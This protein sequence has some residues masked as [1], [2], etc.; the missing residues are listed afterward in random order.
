MANSPLLAIPLLSQSQAAKEQTINQMVS[1]LERATN[2]GQIL[3]FGGGNIV[4]PAVDLQRYFL[5]K[6]SGAASTSILT[7]TP[8]KRIF[9]IDNFSNGNDLTL[10]CTSDSIII[11]AGG[12]VMVYCDG[13]NLANICDSTVNGGSGGATTLLG[14]MDTPNSY[15]ASE[16]FVLRVKNDLTGIEFVDLSIGDLADV[17]LTGVAEGYTLAWD[18]TDSKFVVVD[19]TGAVVN[20]SSYWKAPV[21]AATIE[22]FD[23]DDTVG[24][25]VDGV[26]I[27]DGMSI[28]VKDNVDKSENGIW[29]L[30]TTWARRADALT[31]GDLPLGAA[32][33]VSAGTVNGLNIF[34]MATE[35]AAVGSGNDIEFDI[36]TPAVSLATLDDVDMTTPP[37]DKQ[38][39]TWDAAASGAKFAD[40]EGSYPDLAG[41]AGKVLTVN[42]TSSD[43]IWA[44]AG[45]SS[46]PDMVGNAGKVLAV[47]D[48][49]TDAE[50]IDQPISYTDIVIALF[51]QGAT[52]DGE[53][54][55]GYEAVVPFDLTSFTASL[56][57]AVSASTGTVAFTIQKNG[58]TIGSITFTTSDAGVYS[59][60]GATFA[61]GDNLSVIAPATADPTLANISISLKGIRT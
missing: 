9:A 6:T 43:V 39:L 19:P 49:E 1:F 26:P 25:I 28:L 17:D 3:A 18:A 22:P 29:E 38:V 10:S 12:I 13:T 37:S 57:S 7:I 8:M 24:V 53:Y 48:A 27:I 42:P 31:P 61:I 36:N 46:Y 33:T 16:N 30:N 54:L 35:I 59:G 44:S 58:A 34:F 45:A 15:A 14:L 20:E 47:N 4:L 40:P 56:A 11:P 23:F 41:Q 55:L 60:A 21:N 51:V 5:F 32:V 2:D 50:W 52:A